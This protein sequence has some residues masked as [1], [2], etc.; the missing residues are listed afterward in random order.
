MKFRDVKVRMRN[1][2]QVLSAPNASSQPHEIQ[3]AITIVTSFIDNTA[4]TPCHSCK[5][6]FES[7]LDVKAT[8]AQWRGEIRELAKTPAICIRECSQCKATTCLGCGKNYV[9]NPQRVTDHSIDWCCDDG[10]I[11]TIWIVLCRLDLLYLDNELEQA[12]RRSGSLAKAL[13]PNLGATSNGTGYGSKGSESDWALNGIILQNPSVRLKEDS[14][15]MDQ[16]AA[17]LIDLLVSLLPSDEGEDVPVVLAYMLELSLIMDKSAELLRNDCLE[18]IMQRSAVFRSTLN[19]VEKLGA[20]SSL[21]RLV[22]ASRYYKSQSPGLQAISLVNK[23]NTRSAAKRALPLTMADG[24]NSK[25][26]SVVKGFENLAMQSTFVLQAP[27][28]EF[29][30]RS[31]CQRTSDVY[32]VL[33][34]C[35][36][37]DRMTITN[38]VEKWAQFHKANALSFSDD[39]L[40]DFDSKLLMA[41][42]KVARNL[43]NVRTDGARNKRILTECASMR[44]SLDDGIFVVVAES[45]PDMMKALII[46]PQDTAY[47]HGLFEYV[48]HRH[49][50]MTSSSTDKISTKLDSTFS[51]QKTILDLLPKCTSV[52]LQMHNPPK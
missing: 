12:P 32:N 41:A 50:Y 25:G 31:M 38:P 43:Q 23:P 33:A 7:N 26:Q 52:T 48:L 24:K 2:R 19:L 29:G 11:F 36:P 40:L 6:K 44:T 22:Q 42:D 49:P 27:D 5:R 39:I 51:S 4:S 14:K 28:A 3:E 10:R 16:M 8:V 15:S 30:L 9:T 21:S 18:G 37:H 46:G 13:T 45:R 20:K 47:T 34:K 1:L 35:Q 17:C